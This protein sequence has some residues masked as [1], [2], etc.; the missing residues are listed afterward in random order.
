MVN[1]IKIINNFELSAYMMIEVRA[2]LSPQL[3]TCFRLV[4]KYYRKKLYDKHVSYILL[5][6][7]RIVI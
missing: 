7:G 3:L 2:S 1:G 6:S 4:V 5:C